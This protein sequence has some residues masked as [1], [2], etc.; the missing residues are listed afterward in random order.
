MHPRPWLLAPLTLLL[1]AAPL[2]AQTDGSLLVRRG[3]ADSVRLGAARLAAL[4]HKEVRGIDHGRAA[5]FSGVPLVA[6]LREAGIKVDSLRGP[7]LADVIVVEA[8]D[9]YRVVISLGELSPDLGRADF[10]L[11]D[12]RNGAPLG[13]AEG[14]LRLVAPADGRPARW[15]R[16]VKSITV[17][18][19]DPR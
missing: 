5:A 4:P 17:V 12:R 13:T 16:R 10:V 18:R 19:V 11:A 6:V 15:V 1:S 9:G 2:R 7:A 8:E 3:A 14:P